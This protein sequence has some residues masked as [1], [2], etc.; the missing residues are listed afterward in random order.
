MSIPTESATRMQ[1]TEGNA[2]D[3]VANKQKT[4]GNANAAIVMDVEKK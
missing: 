3:F 2:I 4:E 1:K